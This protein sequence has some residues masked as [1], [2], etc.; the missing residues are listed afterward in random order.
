MIFRNALLDKKKSFFQLILQNR[1]WVV[2]MV[3]LISIV[4]FPLATVVNI[5]RITERVSVYGLQTEYAQY[6][7]LN[8]VSAWIGFR[9]YAV[10]ISAALGFI[11]ALQGFRYLTDSRMMDF[12]GSLPYKKSRVFRNVYMNGIVIY[13]VPWMIGA[14]LSLIIAALF[15]AANQAMLLDVIYG[16]IV[17]FMIFMFVYSVTVLACEM[18]GRT[19]IAAAVSVLML[20]IEPVLEMIFD[21]YTALY[22]KTYYYSSIDLV[23]NGVNPLMRYANALYSVRWNDWAMTFKD[24]HGNMDLLIFPLVLCLVF[25]VL[26]TV[27]ALVCNQKRREEMAGSAFAFPIVRSIA[28]PILTVVAS[29]A[30]TVII[31]SLYSN[32]LSVYTTIISVIGIIIAGIIVSVLLE[33]IMEMNVHA[34]RQHLWQMGIAI[35]VSV[36][37]YSVFR[38]DLMGYDSYIPEADEIESF[39]FFSEGNSSLSDY[40]VSSGD[41]VYDM[42]AD[43]WSISNYYEE[44]MYLT[45]VEDLIPVVK[46]SQAYMNANPEN[47]MQAGFDFTVIYRLKNGK[48]IYRT[49]VLDPDVDTA[50]LDNIMGSDEYHESSYVFFS[51]DQIADANTVQLTFQNGFI[52]RTEIGADLYEEFISNYR[53]DLVGYNYSLV[54]SEDVVGS[55]DVTLT[56]GNG[57]GVSTMTSSYE[58]Y[59]S[60]TNTLGFLEEIGLYH[61]N[62]IS[63]EYIRSL[64]VSIYNE[65][66]YESDYYEI[67]DDDRIDEIAPYLKSTYASLYYKM[68]QDADEYIE[69]SVSADMTEEDG[70]KSY[71]DGVVELDLSK[72]SY[73]DF[74]ELVRE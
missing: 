12:M 20:A 30:V 52:N 16:I 13:I 37:I 67:T 42:N 19:I 5:L 49:I 73:E 69:I 27:L 68:D 44:H 6:K 25:S 10:V 70:E 9:S 47:Y 15:K 41:G 34:G 38:F 17:N 57:S 28:K 43:Y 66:G 51:N 14:F 46:Q 29:L 71:Y 40:Y 56:L 59:P 60:Y 48:T 39:A 45:D 21:F 63:S 22:F 8:A 61:E 35:V 74:L 58:I 31:S 3:S 33:I 55:M 1:K 26:A 65:T 64:S 7:I 32:T 36:A 11:I 23:R 18:T 24:V 53:K 2:L 72:I 4:Y 54:T 62:Y 50:L